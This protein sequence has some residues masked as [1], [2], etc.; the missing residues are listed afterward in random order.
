MGKVH[1]VGPGGVRVYVKPSLGKGVWRK[2]G[3]NRNSAAVLARNEA[4][5]G[6]MSGSG[7]CPATFAGLGIK[8]FITHLRVCARSKNL[9]TGQSKTTAYRRRFNKYLKAAPTVG[10]T[11]R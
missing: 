4:F 10:I 7:G 8:A 11:A 9:G 2:S 3:V 1:Q 5:T 6:A